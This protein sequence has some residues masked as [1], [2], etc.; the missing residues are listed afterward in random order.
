MRVL[1]F[2]VLAFF[3]GTFLGT[4][5]ERHFAPSIEAKAPSEHLLMFCKRWLNQ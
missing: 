2:G 5:V 1:V 3:A 4:A